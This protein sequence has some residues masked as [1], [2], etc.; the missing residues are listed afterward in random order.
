ML[1]GILFVVAG[2][3]GIRGLAFSTML[4]HWTRHAN[5]VVLNLVDLQLA[6]DRLESTSREFALTGN[7]FVLDPDRATSSRVQRDLF[8]IHAWTE[9]GSRLWMRL[10]QLEVLIAQEIRATTMVA[11][12]RRGEG[13]EAT[14][15][16]I[17]VGVGRKITDKRRGLIRELRAEGTHFLALEDEVAT[18]QLQQ[19]EIVLTIETLLAL[20]IGLYSW[21]VHRGNSKRRELAIRLQPHRPGPLALGH[22]RAPGPLV[23]P[24]PTSVIAASVRRT[25]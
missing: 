15:E 9:E 7:E 23:R 18:R 12:V 22:G 3:I 10:P 4:S 2:A 5:D 19:T 8:A 20:A 17:R 25:F 11:Q 16:L 21:A 1:A 14:A 6:L 13:L 24:F